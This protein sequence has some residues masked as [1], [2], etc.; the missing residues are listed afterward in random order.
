MS[1]PRNERTEAVLGSKSLVR[2]ER[3]ADARHRDSRRAVRPDLAAAGPARP[4]TERNMG[5]YLQRRRRSPPGA[6]TAV[7]AAGL[8]D[9]DRGRDAGDAAAERSGVDR[10][11]G[12]AGA[13][14]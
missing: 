7:A 2:R 10:A 8:Q 4:Q 5:C 9:L 3:R 1:E 12:Y 13:A 14:L 11:R 6:R